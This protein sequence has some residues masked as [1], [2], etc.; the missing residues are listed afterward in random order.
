MYVRITVFVSV[1]LIPFGV[2]AHSLGQS[3]EKEVGEYVVDIGY[4]SPVTTVLEGEPIRFDFNLWNKDR[5]VVDFTSVWVRVAPAESGITFA[6]YL[7]YPPFGAVGMSY[8]FP[9]AGEYTLTARFFNGEQTL[10]EATFPLQVEGTNDV[11]ISNS[12]PGL[13]VAGVSGFILGV[14]LLFFFKKKWKA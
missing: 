14:L 10:A 12:S 2:F 6:G 13:I 11:K 4:D 7:G 1:V 3:L 8:T 9:K 5:A